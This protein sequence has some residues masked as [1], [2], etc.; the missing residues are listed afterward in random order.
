MAKQIRPHR[1]GLAVLALIL[2]AAACTTSDDA[3]EPTASET[4]V[5]TSAEASAGSFGMASG[6][7]L[8]KPAR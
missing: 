5:T 3:T 1:V 8:T 7:S 6:G 4:N 2:V